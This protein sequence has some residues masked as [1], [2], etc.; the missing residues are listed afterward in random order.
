MP[1]ICKNVVVYNNQVLSHIANICWDADHKYDSKKFR[2]KIM[3]IS[4][5]LHIITSACLPKLKLHNLRL[6]SR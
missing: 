5:R 4:L 3:Y 6:Q 2:Q 1:F